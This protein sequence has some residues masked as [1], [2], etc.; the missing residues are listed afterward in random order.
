M[1]YTTKSLDK[2]SP[3]EYRACLY[4]NM[5]SSGMMMYSLVDNKDNPNAH[6]VMCWDGTKKHPEKL[7]GW[8]L[9]IPHGDDMSWYSSSWQRKKSKYVTQFY[10]RVPYRQKGIGK[11]LMTL[12]NRLDESPTVI[13]H[14]QQSA[15]FFASH[16]VVT[17]KH[18][19]GLLTSAK[20]NKMK[21][22]MD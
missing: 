3:R 16:H 11:R 19:R 7:L 13:P 20:A 4:L 9:C 10:V 2:L 18:R 8:A 22:R 15:A 6:A 12:V 5:R 14:D 1:F 17:N 21:I